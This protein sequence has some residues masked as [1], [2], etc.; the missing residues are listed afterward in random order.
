MKTTCRIAVSL[1]L[2]LLLSLS[3]V[4]CQ[5]T[6]DLWDSATYLE[7]TE[8]GTGAKTVTVEVTAE[9]KTVTFTLHT[10]EAMLGDALLLHDLIAGEEG[11]YGLYVKVV[12]GITADYDVDQTYWQL[13]V[14]GES[15]MVGVDGTEIEDGATYRLERTK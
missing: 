4:A 9:G 5:T 3:F 2:A 13:F 10:D 7:D 12:N 8:L 1:A 15:A 14:D 6:V 11:A